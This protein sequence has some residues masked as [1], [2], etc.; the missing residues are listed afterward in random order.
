MNKM[1]DEFAK[2]LWD[3]RIQPALKASGFYIHRPSN[4]T[5]LLAAER[6]KQLQLCDY[7]PLPNEIKFKRL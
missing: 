4:T 5:A 7:K 6:L 2:L 3:R 1:I